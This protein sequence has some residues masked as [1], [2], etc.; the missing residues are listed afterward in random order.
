ML[1]RTML[2]L[3]AVALLA[4]CTSPTPPAPAPTSPSAAPSDAED[5]RSFGLVD[6]WRVTDAAGESADTWLR[7]GAGEFQLWR[8]CGM[9][10]GSWR[11]TDELF[12]AS[13][14]AA[15][16]AC[17]TSSRLPA[18]D[19]LDSVA[20]YRAA[21]GGWELTD[22]RG[23]AL[24]RL[25]IDGAPPTDPDVAEFYT[26]PPV[27][28]A[29]T[30]AA[31]AAAGPLPTTLVPAGDLVGR[32]V[33]A[34][35]RGVTDPYVTFTAAGTWEGTDGCN[36]GA[37]RW[38]REGDELLATIG[39][40]TLIACDGAGL[41]SWVASARLIGAEGD[42]LVLLDVDGAELGRLIRA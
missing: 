32:W 38:E 25:T 39:L 3:V 19:W 41:P 6:L 10:T 16:S 42:E 29:A 36:G 8:E 18:V 22:A 33:P 26:Q 28:T 20:G 1:R 13:V 17:A 40:S 15:T 27:I 11:A 9:I 2:A 30:R 37:G 24:A 34:G 7:L 31:L 5:P 14:F 35:F 21:D 12:V 23:A 4:G